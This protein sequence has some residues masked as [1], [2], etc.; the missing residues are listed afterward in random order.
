MSRIRLAVAVVGGVVVVAAVVLSAAC[1]FVLHRYEVPS[2]SMEPTLAPGDSFWTVRFGTAHPGDVVVITPPA[3]AHLPAAITHVVVREVAK[4]GDTVETKD[5]HLVVNGTAVSE[6]Y[7]AAGMTTPNIPRTAVP[8]GTVYVLGD[9]RLNSQGSRVYGPVPVADVTDR[10]VRKNPPPTFVV[11]LFTAIVVT[12]YVL[13][14]Q[15]ARRTMERRKTAELAS[16]FGPD[17]VPTQVSRGDLAAMTPVD[18]K[19]PAWYPDP[20]ERH[21]LRWWDGERWS[22]WARDR[23]REV[24]DPLGD[25]WS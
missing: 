22:S 18:P 12:A 25:D 11:H 2:S 19:A 21:E 20:A 9:N 10:F 4:A 7:L 24:S 16:P 6:P 17:A 1:T 5:G 23:E 14:M 15:R 8:D 3:A 13:W